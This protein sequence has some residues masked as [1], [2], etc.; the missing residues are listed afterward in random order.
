MLDIQ[1]PFIGKTY[2]VIGVIFSAMLL[3]PFTSRKIASV[4]PGRK[5]Q[6]TSSELNTSSSVVKQAMLATAI[7]LFTMFLMVLVVMVSIFMFYLVAKDVTLGETVTKTFETLNKYLWMD[8]Q[9]TFAYIP[10][11]FSS[12]VLLIVFM[13]Y[14]WSNSDFV[15]N[16]EFASVNNGFMTSK[17]KSDKVL[18]QNMSRYDWFRKH[19]ILLIFIASL[20]IYTIIFVPLWNMDKV[21]YVKCVT[22]I[23]MILVSSMAALRKWWVMFIVY[24]LIAIGYVS[25][26]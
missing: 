13:S 24:T 26:S 16:I 2:L 4:L 9:L 11:L 12:I 23:L 14:A 10:I 7:Y 18:N 6:Q 22:L 5:K 8:G 3:G 1:T 15:S 17:K 25:S 21:L 20:F 19:Y